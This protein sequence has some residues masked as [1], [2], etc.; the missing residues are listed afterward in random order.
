MSGTWV[1]GGSS[2]YSFPPSAANCGEGK[3]TA[4]DSIDETCYRIFGVGIV[5]G[6]TLAS[7]HGGFEVCNFN[8]H[9]S[10]TRP[11]VVAVA[12]LNGPVVG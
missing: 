5:I 3:A 8:F 6:D 9:M 11:A 1:D 10:D 12:Q 4:W 7:I 2:P